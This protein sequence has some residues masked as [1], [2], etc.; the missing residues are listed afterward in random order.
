MQRILQVDRLETSVRES[1]VKVWAPQIWKQIHEKKR[2][3]LSNIFDITN[4]GIPKHHSIMFHMYIA[5]EQ[6]HPI[7]S[8]AV[9]PYLLPDAR[10]KS[11]HENLI[12]AIPVR[13]QA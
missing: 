4:E 5:D 1:W 7:L 2:Q 12:W 8:F 6:I 11:K 3:F 9:L 13:H 10:M